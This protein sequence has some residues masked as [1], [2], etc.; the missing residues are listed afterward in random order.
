MLWNISQDLALKSIK[1]S[2]RNYA[3]WI[4]WNIWEDLKNELPSFDLLWFLSVFQSMGTSLRHEGHP[5]CLVNDQSHHSGQLKTSFSSIHSIQF[6]KSLQNIRHLECL[7]PRVLG[8]SY[9]T[10]FT[11][12]GGDGV[13]RKIEGEVRRTFWV[14]PC[15]IFETSASKGQ[16]QQFNC[17][18]NRE[19]KWTQRKDNT[20][21]IV[22]FQ[23]RIKWYF[24]KMNLVDVLCYV[25]FVLSQGGHVGLPTTTKKETAT[26]LVTLEGL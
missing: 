17:K 11:L 25:P 24:S 14:F 26:H 13:G 21:L 8:T 20:R 2:I 1:K 4:Y 3:A 5:M 16:L 10:S 7:S 19:T 18:N 9:E 12:G 22:E 23:K 6:R 15:V